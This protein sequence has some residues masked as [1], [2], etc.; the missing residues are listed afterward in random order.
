MVAQA[1]GRPLP[2]AREPLSSRMPMTITDWALGSMDDGLYPGTSSSAD[3]G[4]MP[5]SSAPRDLASCFISLASKLY[6]S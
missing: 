1:T 6:A 3:A 2:L 5:T 4:A